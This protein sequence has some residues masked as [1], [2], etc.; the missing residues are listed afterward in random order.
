MFQKT[1]LISALVTGAAILGFSAIASADLPGFYAGGELG[2][3]NIH[4]SDN[5]FNS[6]DG[7]TGLGAGAQIGYQFNPYI[8]AEAGY[9]YFHNVDQNGNYFGPWNATYKE[10]A[11]DLVAKG[12]LPLN[13]YISLYGKAGAAYVDAQTEVTGNVMTPW[14]FPA[15]GYSATQTYH[16]IRPVYGVGVSYNIA[17]NVS[18]D[19]GWTRVQSNSTIPNADIATLGLTYHF[20]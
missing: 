18:A 1:A 19:L 4:D 11:V 9:L 10:Q 13:Q 2:L 3:S 6:E 20:G 16:P 15:V 17:P 12:T 8:A 14:G 5:P 7:G